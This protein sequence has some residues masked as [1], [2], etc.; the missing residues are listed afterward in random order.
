MSQKFIGKKWNFEVAPLNWKAPGQ[1]KESESKPVKS[2]Q[3]H[4]SEA[5]RRRAA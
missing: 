2:A 4:S 3:D 1:K 5:E